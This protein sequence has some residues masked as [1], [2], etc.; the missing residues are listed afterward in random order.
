MS[1][2][3]NLEKAFNAYLNLAKAELR[4]QQARP[5]NVS[6]LERVKTL[7]DLVDE[8][9][10]CPEFRELVKQTLVAFPSEDSEEPEAT[11]FG[12][13]KIQNFLRRSRCY[14][15]IYNGQPIEAGIAFRDLVNRFRKKQIQRRYLIP[16]MDVGF[17]EAV[18]DFKDFQVRRFS[19][20]ELEEILANDVN[21]A[22]Y[23]SS[24]VKV[25]KIE[26]HWF[27][28]LEQFEPLDNPEE[29]D[30][31]PITDDFVD[32]PGITYDFVRGPEEPAIVRALEPFVLYDW[33]SLKGIVCANVRFKTAFHLKSSNYLLDAP[34]WAPVIETYDNE[35]DE[36]EQHWIFVDDEELAS[37]HLFVTQIFSILKRL[38]S[39]RTEW[40]FIE[41]ALLFL[42]I[43]FFSEGLQQLLWHITVIEALLGEKKEGLTDS[44]GRRLASVLGK[45]EQERKGIKASFKEIYDLR[46]RLVHG[47][48]SLLT[49]KADDGPLVQARFLAIRTS[50]WFLH[51]LDHV[52]S[53]TSINDRNEIGLPTRE[54]LL[55]VLDF[56]IESRERI[57]H[58]LKIL[59]ADFP[60]TSDWLDP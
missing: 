34:H 38:R 23:E 31:L 58:L 27:I 41:V 33:D 25:S 32:G 9:E 46:S 42:R 48:K 51:Y 29:A 28:D 35:T 55:G 52:L 50:V 13:S 60:R 53:E 10:E 5:S 3:S 56:K 16:L 44:L 47:D 26:R 59:P 49:M 14:T 22:F 19:A 54:E 24:A 45:T 2:E 7:G 36:E 4:P 20:E 39:A 57:K 37:F 21:K 15:S 1:I 12:K 18:I 40:L 6:R 11:R 43:A 8:I 17:S 30:I